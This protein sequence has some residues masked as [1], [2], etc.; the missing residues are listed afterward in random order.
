MK[1]ERLYR[2]YGETKVIFW[3]LGKTEKKTESVGRQ[4]KSNII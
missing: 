3:P 4:N 1:T 2:A